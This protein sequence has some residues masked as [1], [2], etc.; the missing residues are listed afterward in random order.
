MMAVWM[1]ARGT[2]QVWH[3]RVDREIAAELNLAERERHTACGAD[4]AGP[5]D[6]VN[7]PPSRYCRMCDMVA[8]MMDGPGSA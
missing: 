8:Q 3:R 7:A 6:H 1:R 2:G 5:L 4:L